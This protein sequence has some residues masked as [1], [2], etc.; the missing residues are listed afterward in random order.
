MNLLLSYILIMLGR[1]NNGIQTDRL[2]VLIVLYGYLG[3]SIRTKIRKGSVLTNLSQ[4]SCKLVSQSDR[5]RHVLLGLIRCITEHHTLISCTNCIEGIVIHCIFLCLK[6]L[7]NAESDIGRLLVKCNHN[8]TGIAVKTILC[9]VI[10]DLTNRLT[11]NFLNIDICI[12]GNLSHYHNKTGRTASLT[13]YTAH[14]VLLHQ[15]IQNR[16]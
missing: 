2:A 6:C 8:A 13:C 12:C 11:N 3:L 5:V 15:S 4:T 7:V 9:T 1:K 10:S 14:R 16:I